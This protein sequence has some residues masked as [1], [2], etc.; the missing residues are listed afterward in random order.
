MSSRYIVDG[1][2]GYAQETEPV[3]PSPSCRCRQNLGSGAAAG[4]PLLPR[5]SDA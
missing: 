1:F 2:L 5:L 3:E 4:P